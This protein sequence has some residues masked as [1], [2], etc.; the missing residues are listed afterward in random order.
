[1][2]RHRYIYRGPIKQIIEALGLRN[3]IAKIYARLLWG[4]GKEKCMAEIEN[5][6]IEFETSNFSE[7]HRV[8]YNSGESDVI[9]DMINSHAKDKNMLDVGANIGIYTCFIGK[10]LNDGAVI[11][12]EPHPINYKKLEKNIM[13]SNIN[14]NAKQIALF[15]QEGKVQFDMKSTQAGEGHGQITTAS[16]NNNNNE[17]VDTIYGDILFTDEGYNVPATIKIDVEGAEVNVLAGLR[18]TLQNPA[19]ERLYC[20]VHPN[21]LGKYD[22]SVNELFKIVNDCGF[23]EEK[24]FS[25][26]ENN[27]LI[28]FIK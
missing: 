6:E 12:C 28:K 9:S 25:H 26:G 3:K 16:D 18:K 5:I 7:F 22:H 20:E 2:R 27:Y 8:L 10:Y 15:D 4:K 11:S 13:L 21:H 1:M 17:Y 23:Y 24:K 19:C 14:A